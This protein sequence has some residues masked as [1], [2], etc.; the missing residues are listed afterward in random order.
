[1]ESSSIYQEVEQTF[2]EHEKCGLISI[3][4]L[5]MIEQWVA[6]RKRLSYK[7]MMKVKYV[8]NCVYI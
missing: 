8:L 1:M 4:F 2:L 7:E 5:N 6:I 3:D